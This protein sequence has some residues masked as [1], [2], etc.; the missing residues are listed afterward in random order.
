MAGVRDHTA[1]IVRADDRMPAP[2]DV[3]EKSEASPLHQAATPAS[4]PAAAGGRRRKFLAAIGVVALT[5]AGYFGINYYF[6]GQYMVS[7]DDAYVRSANTTLGS[8]VPGHIVDILPRDNSVVGAGD[9]LVRIDP[10]DYRIAVEA[11]R[12]RIATQNAMIERIGRQVVAQQS[13]LEQTKAQLTAAEAAAM[14]AELDFTRQESLS[15]KGFA[16]Q[17]TFET[18]QAGRDQSTAQVRAAKAAFAAASSQVEVVRAQQQEAKAQ[19]A[20]LINALSKAERD[21]ASTDLRAPVNGIF[22]NRLVA[23]G[24]YVQAGQRLANVVPLDDVYIDANLKETQLARIV[25]GQSVGISIDAYS[26]RQVTGVVESLSPAAGAVFTLL[27]PDNATGNFTKIVQR[28]PV[29]IRVPADVAQE[30]LLRAGMSV[31]VRIDTRTGP[32]AAPR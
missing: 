12:S 32:S 22:S 5:G 28:V 15:A 24:D 31:F 29:R 14:R 25:P 4:P 6:V 13:T 2:P 1:R 11:A 19:M 27:P 3:L 17:A 18:A 20:E 21:L 8:R 16:S 26:G 10:T 23:K 7:T 30:N 9:V